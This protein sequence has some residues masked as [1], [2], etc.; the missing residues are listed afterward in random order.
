MF[1]PFYWQHIDLLNSQ[2]FIIITLRFI[3]IEIVIDIENQV[4]IFIK[5]LSCSNEILI[6]FYISLI[7]HYAIEIAFIYIIRE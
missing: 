7:P 3:N 2:V 6:F 1:G 4:G 5:A